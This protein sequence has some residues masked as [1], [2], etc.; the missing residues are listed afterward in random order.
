MSFP[1]PIF[2]FTGFRSIRAVNEFELWEQFRNFIP[3]SIPVS[4]SVKG[5]REK[6]N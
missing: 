1:D 5:R 2:I 3:N 6:V 4:N